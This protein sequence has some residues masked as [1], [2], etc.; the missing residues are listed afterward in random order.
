MEE[1]SSLATQLWQWGNSFGSHEDMRPCHP[2]QPLIFR[3]LW[4]C[5]CIPKDGTY[6]W[7]VRTGLAP[8]SLIVTQ[9]LWPM[10]WR[11]GCDIVVLSTKMADFNLIFWKVAWYQL[12]RN[13]RWIVFGFS[14]WLTSWLL[15]K[16]RLLYLSHVASC[17]AQELL[18]RQKFMQAAGHQTCCIR[19]GV[20]GW[21]YTTLSNSDC[22]TL[23][24]IEGNP[25]KWCILGSDWGSLC[26]FFRQNSAVESFA[27]KMHILLRK[28]YRGLFALVPRIATEW[29][30]MSHYAMEDE[31]S[32]QTVY[33]I[34]EFDVGF[35]ASKSAIVRSGR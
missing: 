15:G 7:P 24:I 35:P 14:T 4:Y 31:L 9:R 2:F 13:M 22:T 16:T 19:L 32:F 5:G 8:M 6:R 27:V 3:I 11:M 10:V 1:S 34:S 12:W 29:N 26:S 33:I 20:I 28:L 23:V 25:T 30:H 21:A 18:Q 17:K